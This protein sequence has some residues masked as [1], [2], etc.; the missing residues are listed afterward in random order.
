MSATFPFQVTAAP[1]AVMPEYQL[2]IFAD[3]GGLEAYYALFQNYGF[4]GTADSWVEHIETI[5][6]EKQPKL[7]EELEFAEGGH[8]FVAYASGPVA[9][10]DFMACVLPHFDTLP[11]LQ[12]Y[13]SQADP[14]DFFA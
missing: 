8:T 5:I 13:L 10:A 4:G 12:K 2:L 1:A 14:D 7:L 6:E 9:V 3:V 11:H